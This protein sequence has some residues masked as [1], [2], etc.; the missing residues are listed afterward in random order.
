MAKEKPV[1]VVGQIVGYRNLKL[2]GGLRVEIDFFEAREQD[3]MHMALLG[4]RKAVVSLSITPHE[5]KKDEG[6]G[7]KEYRQADGT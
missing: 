7:K 1:E 6:K 4:N 2:A 5:E 3:I